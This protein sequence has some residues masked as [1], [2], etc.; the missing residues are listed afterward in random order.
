[1]L[2]RLLY[3]DKLAQAAYLIGCQ[4]TGEA[5]IIDPERDVERYLEA[6]AK[7]GVRIVAA[8]ETHIHADF[9]SGVRELAERTG[10]HVYLS[11]EGDTDWKY[12]WLGKKS[13]GGEYSHTLLKHGS[14][15]MIGNIE[16][17]AVHTA[18]HTPEHMSFLVTDRGS[19]IDA[20]MGIATGDFVFVGDVGRPDLLETA[21]GVSGASETSAKALYQSIRRFQ[22]LPDYLQLWPGHGSGSACGKALGA[23][24]QSTVGYEKRFNPALA[25][26]RSERNFIDAVLHGQPEPPLYFARMK[27]ENKEGPALL[28]SLP[29]PRQMTVAELAGLDSEN[30]VILDTRPWADF[31]QGHLPGSLYVPRDKSF[32][33]IAG[34]YVLP[35]TEI[36]LVVA[37]NRLREAVTDLI[38]IGLDRVTGYI[39]PQALAES[40]TALATTKHSSMA[41]LAEID[42]PDALILDVRKAVEFDMGSVPGAKNIVHTRLAAHLDELPKEKTILVHCQSGIRS[43]YATA[44]LA[45]RGFDAVQLDGGYLAWR[46]A[47]A[48]VAR[49]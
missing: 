29:Q 38:R 8:T 23:V 35:E 24:P 37:E 36:I 11:D 34:S 21:A 15:F 22:D 46:Q 13:E 40:K 12:Q 45:S 26:A 19:G 31:I 41:D 1:M 16:F 48:Q 17:E 39:V 4:K 44:L 10:A 30:T 47:L 20:P 7:E 9:L 49:S 28:G 27:K 14:K 6:A 2:F 25:E 3:D 5:I 32:T 43:A 42:G 33:T 18:G